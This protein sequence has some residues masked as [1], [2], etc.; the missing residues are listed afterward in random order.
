MRIEINAGGLKGAIAVATFAS[1]YDKLLSRHEDVVSAFKEVKSNVNNMSGGV[2]NLQ[3]AIDCIDNRITKT[4]E[5][6]LQRMEGAGNRFA[7]FLNNAV[8]TDK[9]VAKT[10]ALSNK[11]FYNDNPWAVPPKPKKW[12]QKVKDFFKKIGSAIWNG[13]KKAVNWV[14]DKVKKAVKATIAFIKKHWKAIVK[15]VVGVV[16][17]AGLAALSVFTGGAA[18]IA[19]AAAAKAAV[20][21][22][23]TS[24]ATTVVK[25]V[26]QG[27]SFGEI[28]DSA[29]DSFMTGAITGAVGGAAGAAGSAVLSSTG[30]QL[31]SKAA[32]IGVKA[33]GDTL[34]KG[35]RYLIENG[36]LSGFIKQEGKGILMGAA[37]N[38][39][40]AATEYLKGAAS[41]FLKDKFS[42]LS[43]SSLGQSF[44]SFYNTM[45]EK[46]P[47]LTNVL[48]KSAKDFGNSFSLSDLSKLKN[49][50]EFAKEIGNRALG[51]LVSNAKASA[52]DFITNDLNNLTGGAVSSVT[53]KVS[54]F[55][56]G[57]TGQFKTAGSDILGSA[58]QALGSDVIS[59]GKDLLTSGGS[60]FGS[61]IANAVSKGASGFLGNDYKLINNAVG[62]LVNVSIPKNISG[63]FSN[64]AIGTSKQAF[65]KLCSSGFAGSMASGISKATGSGSSVLSQ[66]T[67]T[68][69]S[70]LSSIRL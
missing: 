65:G 25:G 27:K 42:A 17:I 60:N 9:N 67:Q 61:T 45:Q 55:M 37:G 64:L 6:Q 22:A 20:T 40:G 39:L 35:T 24:A 29:A 33:A 5:A 18:S 26:V 4:E 12:W 54:D 38:A 43:E 36:T 31:L 21:C 47:T 57:L 11:E 63:T 16:I 53:N 62:Q 49:P 7:A 30:S 2:G 46:V 69:S 70:F 13:L 66:T 8:A 50:S 51:S 10:I 56:G 15:I 34:V 68:V 14:I 28:F 41:D 1:N 3:T 58:K 48:T 52:G 23:L 44:K 19:L 59:F 32:E